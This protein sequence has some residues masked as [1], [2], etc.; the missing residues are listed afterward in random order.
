MTEG[1]ENLIYR[2]SPSGMGKESS[3][4]AP[5]LFVSLNGFHYVLVT[6][7]QPETE[8][9]VD[10]DFLYSDWGANMKVKFS[11]RLLSISKPLILLLKRLKEIYLFFSFP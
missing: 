8:T 1:I 6:P 11:N 9:G 7:S 5:S 4:L 3:P 2:L 10:G